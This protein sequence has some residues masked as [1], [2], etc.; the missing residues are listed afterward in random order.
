MLHLASKADR[1]SSGGKDPSSKRFIRSI[2]PLL[3]VGAI[4]I[5]LAG[6]ASDQF[7]GQT[8]IKPQ[9]GSAPWT[10]QAPTQAQLATAGSIPVT[11]KDISTPIGTT[12]PA[13]FGPG[14]KGAVSL[15]TIKAGTT[16]K[17][18]FKNQDAMPH[19]FTVPS[20]GLNVMVPPMGSITQSIV[21]KTAGTYTWYCSVPCGSWVMT[22]DGY[23]KGTFTV[24]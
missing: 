13:Y 14:G 5:T 23:M 7:V 24:S 9:Q 17:I 19:T 21:A 8:A 2:A 18:V 4:A 20:L 6:C 10:T 15:F 12:E 22:H 3:G 11:I 1:T 16:E